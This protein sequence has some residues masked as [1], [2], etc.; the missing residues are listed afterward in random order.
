[1]SDAKAGRDALGLM[2]DQLGELAHNAEA[3][4]VL[5]QSILDLQDHDGA[6]GGRAM[7]RGDWC[8]RRDERQRAG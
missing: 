7:G 8:A 5:N 2:V 1:M 4:R 3:I 6:R